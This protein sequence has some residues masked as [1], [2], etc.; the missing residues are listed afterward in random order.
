MIARIVINKHIVKAN[1]KNGTNDAPI[2][3]QTS[4]GV[5]RAHEVYLSGPA[6]LVYRPDKPLKCGASVWLEVRRE[7]VTAAVSGGNPIVGVSYDDLWEA[8]HSSTIETR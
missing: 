6:K 4:R 1:A 5:E 3:I 7:H 8:S 2:S